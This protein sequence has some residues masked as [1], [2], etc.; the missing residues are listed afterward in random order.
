MVETVL[1]PYARRL[2]EMDARIDAQ[3]KALQANKDKWSD[4]RRRT[5]ICSGSRNPDVRWYGFLR[6]VT[7]A[8]F[9]VAAGRFS[10]R[11]G[12]PKADAI[13]ALRLILDQLRIPVDERALG[14][15][16]YPRFMPAWRREMNEPGGRNGNG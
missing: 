9:L 15:K 12:F 2:A 7:E 5:A 13:L 3:L 16:G 11:T 10:R 8:S 1:L 4:G 6:T 14:V